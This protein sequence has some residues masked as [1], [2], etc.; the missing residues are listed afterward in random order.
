MILRSHE[1][2]RLAPPPA[3]GPLIAAITGTG[4]SRIAR[5]AR[6]PA[7][8]RRRNSFSSPWLTSSLRTAM[9]APAQKPRPSPITTI[10]RTPSPAPA[11]SIASAMADAISTPKALSLSGR[12]RR[13][14]ATD[15]SRETSTAPAVCAV[16]PR[17]PGS[18][19]P[20]PASRR[21]LHEERG[22]QTAAHA[23]RSD[24]EPAFG[25]L[26]LVQERNDDPGAGR[27]D[28]VTERD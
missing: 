18:P 20:W 15:P 25:P 27:A 21:P 16:T 24:P 9:S 13:T 26:H 4:S 19:P 3:A 14:V 22:A 17:I 28:R 12:E 5:I 6:S 1:R 8:R 10:A 23:Q 7:S 11:A 2:A